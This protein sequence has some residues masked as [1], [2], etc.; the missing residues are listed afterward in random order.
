VVD[1]SLVEAFLSGDS[2]GLQPGFMAISPI[3]LPKYLFLRIIIFSFFY[4]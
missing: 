2:K 4:P 1:F 3:M